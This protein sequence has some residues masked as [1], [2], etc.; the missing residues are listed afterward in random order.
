MQTLINQL[1]YMANLHS[2]NSITIVE[3]DK[4][5]KDFGLVLESETEACRIYKSSDGTLINCWID[6]NFSDWLGFDNQIEWFIDDL[7]TQ[8]DAAKLANVSIAA[9]NNAI[10]DGRLRGYRI[11]GSLPGKP[12]A[13]QVSKIEV[14]KAWNL[15]ES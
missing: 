9:I 14:I 4:V 10:A 1:N 12:G 2:N 3:I 15:T 5:V 11:K 8:S 13:N 7:I 6:A